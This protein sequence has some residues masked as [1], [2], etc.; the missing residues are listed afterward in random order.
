MAAVA[1]ALGLAVLPAAATAQTILST[2]EGRSSIIPVKDGFLAV[3]FKESTIGTRLFRDVLI[4]LPKESPETKVICGNKQV[5]IIKDHYETSLNTA[6]SAQKG[7]R[8]LFE[9]GEFTPGL[10]AEFGVARVWELGAP[11]PTPEQCAAENY[12]VRSNGHRALF[13]AV[14]GTVVSRDI[15]E[16]GGTTKAALSSKTGKTMGIKMAFN[17]AFG[18][19]R[20]LGF[21]ATAG[22]ERDSPGEASASNV[23]VV[24]TTG[25]DAKGNVVR[26]ESCKARFAKPLADFSVGTLRMDFASKLQP[27]KHLDRVQLGILA[28]ASVVLRT[29]LNS[30]MN[31]AVGPTLHPKGSPSKVQGA[32]MLELRDVTNANGSHSSLSDKFSLRLYAAF[33]F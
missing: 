4:A 7:K 14:T 6:L 21:A 17:R 33:P 19:T 23:C 1:L 18:D 13:F 20:V 29:G 32:L 11:A 3:D 22:I 9:S 31:L 25:T 15:V 10:E 2:A 5:P 28:S 24:D 30:V 8:T 27:G 12:D 16:G 26:V